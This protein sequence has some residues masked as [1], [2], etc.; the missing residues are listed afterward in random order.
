MKKLVA[1]IAMFSLTFSLAACGSNEAPA[2]GGDSAAATEDAAPAASG[3]GVTVSI[4]K[5][6]DVISMNS[7]YATDGMSFEMIH[8][9]VDGLMD[10]D[11]E[12]NI[13]NALA[14]EYTE[15]EDGLV[16]T[17]TIRDDAVWSNDEP[18]T[19]ND[20][21]FAWQTAITSPEAE[22]A[23][24]YTTGNASIVNA[25][26]VMAGEMDKSELGVK[27]IDDKTLEITLTQKTP[28]FL[29][30]MTF[31]VFYPV[32]EAFATE[33]GDQYGMAPE[34]LLACGPYQLVTREVGT[35]LE[36]V[37]NEK[38]W[39]A[40]NVSVDNLVINI[41]PEV[42]SSV[43]AYEAGSVDFT[44]VSSSL[45]DGYKDNEGFT[46]VLE[47]YLWYLQPN[48]NDENLSNENLRMAIAYAL[49]KQDLADNVLK[50]GSIVGNGF[51]PTKLATGP[52]G[53]DFRA[54]GGEFLVPDEATALEYFAAAQEE[55]GDEITIKMLYENAD[56]AKTAAEYIQ[57]NLQSALPGL[58]VEM[59]MQT[60][61]ARIEMQK[62]RDFQIVLTRWGPDYADPTTY[63]NLM[64]TGNSYNYGDY[65]N[66]EYDALMAEA[67][68]NPDEAARWEQL[69]E[70]EA[71]LMED[72]P[73]ISVF[74]VGGAS[75]INPS[76]TGIETHAV[77]VPYVFKNIKV[78]E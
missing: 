6:N 59:D 32:N 18:V 14:S 54:T 63:L 13:I 44:K 75:L 78:A 28:Y 7:M 74:Q 4:A 29:S 20:F 49:N 71:M 36:F 67:A 42:S 15:S 30:L 9:T 37:K 22:Y 57:S 76:V 51:V 69:L 33:Q 40:A 10:V 41:T 72:A 1:L 64:V 48:M 3:D 73:V 31:P 16:Y 62:D 8:A 23:Y 53:A 65:S 34:N 45:I 55:L 21:V 68:S 66:P 19:A 11:A 35:K 43:T 24:L 50:D 17:F 58:I 77:G 27:A 38:Y 47:G 70:A 12:G 46:Q 25:D 61:E 56:P 39:D 2:E 60:K 5:E 26:E 52:D